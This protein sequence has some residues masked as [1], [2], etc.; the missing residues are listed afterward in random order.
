MT[1]TA[2]SS[3]PKLQSR[4]GPARR[5][6][7]LPRRIMNFSLGAL[8]LV[9]ITAG[10]GATYE[11]IASANDAAAYPPAGLLID[12][13]GYELHLDC[14]GQGAPTI[15]LDAGLGGS[16]LD[17]NLVQP[18]LARTTTVCTYDRAGMGWSE[19]GP[20]P[21][22]PSQLAEELHTLL[23][24]GGIAGPYVLV[25]HSLAGKNIR[26][27]AATHPTEVVGMVLIDARSETIEAEADM[28]AF[29]TAL[30]A[31]AATYSLARSFGIARLFGGAALDMPLVPPALATQM[32]LFATNQAAIAETTQEG[33]NRTADDDALAAATLGS[34][35][36]TVVA[37]GDNMNDPTWAAAQAAMSELST[38]GQL[39]VAAGSGHAV[40]LDKPAIVIDAIGRVVDE[41]AATTRPVLNQPP[42]RAIPSGS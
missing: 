4:T 25:G 37:A 20:E 15:V 28:E 3:D 34:M 10:A 21:R 12:I 36:L 32:A 11:W 8:G 7:R 17:W 13:G 41:S 9:A 5:E 38:N 42:D 27:F 30:E 16:S 18:E 24:S 31:Q 19:V 22:S 29:A 26:M 6:E 39:I 35:P 33:L 23:R 2:D 40:H 1:T 14:R